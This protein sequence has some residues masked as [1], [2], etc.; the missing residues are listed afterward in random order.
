MISVPN[1][2]RLREHLLEASAWVREQLRRADI[3]RSFTLS[4]SAEGMIPEEGIKLIYRLDCMKNYDSAVE[5]NSLSAV[6]WELLRRMG[7]KA[8][9]AGL[10]LEWKNGAGAPS[11][12]EEF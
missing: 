6:T 12:D 9:N 1:E 11:L 4:I 3:D 5:G 8:D 7:W 10:Q 2:A